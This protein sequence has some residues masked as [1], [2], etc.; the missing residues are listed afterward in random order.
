MRTFLKIVGGLLASTVFMFAQIKPPE[1]RFDIQ[2]EYTKAAR[3]AKLQGFVTLSL[4]VD[5]QGNPR[6]IHV[7][8]PLGKGLDENAVEALKKWVF[9]P[10]TKDGAP[11]DYK[12]QVDVTFKLKNTPPVK[13]RK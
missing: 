13:E 8:R 2:P 11:I 12:A 3:K 6:E 1:I 5:K 10:A 7:I 4:I 9:F